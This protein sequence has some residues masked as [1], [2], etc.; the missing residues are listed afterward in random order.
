VFSI[1]LFVDNLLSGERPSSP[2]ATAFEG[3]LSS[4][5]EEERA[6]RI[7]RSRLRS[8]PRGVEFV[9]SVGASAQRA[10]E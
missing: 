5:A 10:I 7:V 6:L 1:R 2:S 8:E 4:A 3:P 9:R